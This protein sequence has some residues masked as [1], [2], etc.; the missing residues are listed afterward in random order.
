MQEGYELEVGIVNN[1]VKACCRA[2]RPSEA[3]AILAKSLE[4]GLVPEVSI[5]WWGMTCRK[6]YGSMVPLHLDTQ[7]TGSRVFCRYTLRWLSRNK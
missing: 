3:E 1:A 5:D 4:R 7:M 6:G 2:G